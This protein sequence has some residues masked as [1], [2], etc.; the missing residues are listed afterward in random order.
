MEPEYTPTDETPQRLT[1][2]DLIKVVVVDFVGFARSYLVNPGPPLMYIAIWLIGMDAVAGGIELSY[3]YGEQY[4]VDNWFFAWI[5]IIVGGAALGV[6]R[7]WV[8]GSIF[9]I[10]VVLAGGTGIAR[11]SRYIL[12]YALLPASVTNLSIK[13][14]QMLIYQNGYFAGDRNVAIESLF[15]LLM[16][17]AYVFTIVLCF[18][19][20]C[21]LQ[22]ADKR[23]ALVVLA[24]LSLGTILLTIIGL[25]S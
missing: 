5:R 13:I 17:V 6:F 10:V 7:Y 15:G 12:L 25:G 9:H 11:T 4:D 23:R 18:R 22:Q 21:A 8:V 16:I 20:M 19:G 24:A 2:P 3:V 1:F 14:I